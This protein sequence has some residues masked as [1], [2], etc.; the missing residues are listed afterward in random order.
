[1]CLLHQ[2][3]LKETIRFTKKIIIELSKAY[4]KDLLIHK[5]KNSLEC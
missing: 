4:S 2:F 3:V 5:E 1:M